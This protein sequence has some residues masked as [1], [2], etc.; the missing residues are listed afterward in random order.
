MAIKLAHSSMINSPKN[1][2]TYTHAQQLHSSQANILLINVYCRVNSHK[3]AFFCFGF[4]SIHCCCF[5]LL[6]SLNSFTSIFRSI[7]F[8]ATTIIKYKLPINQLHSL[9]LFAFFH[10]FFALALFG[11]N[12]NYDSTLAKR[13]IYQ[14]TAFQCTNVDISYL[15]LL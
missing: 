6:L 12:D 10:T 15:F 9:I 4:G 11:A 2:N 14:H 1:A 5:L 13:L 8:S 3:W 7:D